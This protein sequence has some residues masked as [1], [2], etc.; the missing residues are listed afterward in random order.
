MHS[1]RALR[2]SYSLQLLLY[3]FRRPLTLIP[4]NYVTFFSK[5]FISILLFYYD[6]YDFQLNDS[7][8]TI[9]LG[10]TKLSILCPTSLSVLSLNRLV[11]VLI[12]RYCWPFSKPFGQFVH[13][14]FIIILHYIHGL[15]YNELMT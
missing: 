7:D 4:Y 1:A 8:H 6:Y 14:D 2:V 10:T 11:F 13:E 15:L 9:S 12:S 3:L 5:I